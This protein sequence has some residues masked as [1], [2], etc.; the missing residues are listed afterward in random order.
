MC[1]IWLDNVPPAQQ[2]APTD[3]ASAARNLPRNGRLI[4]NDAARNPRLPIV[5]SLK[6]PTACSRVRRLTSPRRRSQ[7][8][9]TASRSSPIARTRPQRHRRGQRA[10]APTNQS[11]VH[12]PKPSPTES[13]ISRLRRLLLCTLVTRAPTGSRPFPP[14][15]SRS[16]RRRGA[17][18][19]T[20]DR[21]RADSR[22]VR[23]DRD[24][25]R[26]PHRDVSRARAR[27]GGPRAGA[28]GTRLRDRRRHRHRQ[29]ARRSADRRGD[30]ARPVARRRGESRARGD[31]RDADRG[32]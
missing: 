4:Y 6:E 17:A 28:R 10:F 2:P 1:R 25:A 21:H 12:C 8:V 16:V 9:R 30:P 27:R 26:A 18:N 23:D 31:A 20:R 3:C 15:R 11:Q 5:K 19:R 32:T 29:D 13:P 14:S 7:S 22:G 24:R